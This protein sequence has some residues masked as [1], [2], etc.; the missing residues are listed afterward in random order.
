MQRQITFLALSSFYTTNSN[1]EEVM[2]D[3]E[4][5]NMPDEKQEPATKA[6]EQN[7]PPETE[8]EDAS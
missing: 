7:Q 3:T 5:N 6:R 8:N 1:K 4:T 2:S